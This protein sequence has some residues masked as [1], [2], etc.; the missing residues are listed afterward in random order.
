[1]I[2]EEIKWVV[3]EKKVYSSETSK[4][5]AMKFLRLNIN[6]DYNFRMNDVDRADQLRNSYRFDHWMRKRKWWWSIFFWGMGVLMVN[7]YVSY[8][9]FNI[10][11]GKKKKDLLSH[12]E[13]RKQI[14]LAWLDP[15]TYW[16]EREL[17]S[18]GKKRNRSSESIGSDDTRHTR[19]GNIRSKSKKRFQVSN[20][21]LAL[22]TGML[23]CRLDTELLHWPV[24]SEA[25]RAKCALHYWAADLEEKKI[26]FC[27]KDAIFICVYFASKHFTPPKILLAKRKKSV[28]H[29]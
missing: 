1:M 16:P 29:S 2:A 5:E 19:S 23:G 14:A 10:L 28:L 8:V 18:K 12:Y 6:S 13:F 11:N 22:H 21:S 17:N 15:E 9:R 25:K 27:V 7:A 3:C 24:A 20:T 4:V 26:L